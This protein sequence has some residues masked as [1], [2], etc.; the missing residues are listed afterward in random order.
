MRP[1]RG[2][3]QASIR[4]QLVATAAISL[5]L[6]CGFGVMAATTE[7]SGAVVSTGTLV[8]ESAVKKVAHPSGGVIADILIREGSHVAAGD[9]LIRLD[10]TIPQA[11]F[12][13][14]TMEQWGLEARR[15]RLEAQRDGKNEV[16]FPAELDAATTAP[17]VARLINGERRLFELQAEALK[18]QKAQLRERIA[19]LNNQVTGLTEQIAAKDTEL[20]LIQQELVGV[21]QLWAK[22]LVPIGRVTALERDQARLRGERGALVASV[23]QSK[24]KVAETELQIIQLDENQHSDVA[25]ELS[26]VL[27]KFS[28]VKERRVA[29]AE[30]LQRI[31]IRAP[32]SG[33]VHQ[34]AVHAP[35]AVVTPGEQ[36]MLIVP[37]SDRL[38]AEVH[39][40]PQEIDQVSPEQSALVRFP[41]FNRRTTPQ[42]NGT[43]KLVAADVTVN[44]HSNDS[45]YL[46]RIVVPPAEI[47]RLR[48][49]RLI[50]GM[51]VEVFIR[52]TERTMMSYLLKP[53]S[54]QAERAFREK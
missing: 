25:K 51:P 15:A 38:I 12:D 8:V 16:A 26:D 23:A 36:I 21:Q 39:V 41:S 28:D 33:T 44:E 22:N 53:L 10:R 42:L 3:A 14:L 11:N 1:H 54:D 18:G 13:A 32:Q 6:I 19:Q 50:P 45:Y 5:A 52:T 47:A 35:G 9:L 27:T 30:Q 37:D 20:D 24:E 34:L 29:A 40:S 49:A 43:V 48:G 4:R 46:V 17:D 31:E 7:L 2:S